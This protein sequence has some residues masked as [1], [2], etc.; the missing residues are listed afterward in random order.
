MLMTAGL[1]ACKKPSED[2]APSSG[3]NELSGELTG[4]RT[5]TS[6][7]KWLLKG[8]VYVPSGSVLTIEPGT[9]ITGGAQAA[10]IIEPGGK[11]MA[12]GTASNPIVFTSKADAGVRARGNWAGLVIAG[13]AQV[14]NA[15][16]TSLPICEGGIRTH[17]GS[18]TNTQDNESSGILKYVRVEYAGYA[19]IPGSE[20]NGITYSG[21]GRGTT[22]EYVQSSWANDDGMEFFGGCVN[23]KHTIIISAIDDD[24]DTDNGYSGKVQFGLAIKQEAQADQSG[25]K[26]FES[27]N[28]GQA[29]LNLP[30]TSCQFSNM[31]L[32]GPVVS[33][34]DSR[35]S[36]NAPTKNIPTFIAGVHVRR[37]SSL[38]LHNSILMGWNY[39]VLIDSKTGTSGVTCANI[40]NGTL[41]MQNNI[42]AGISKNIPGGTG[43][44]D[45]R[46]YDVVSVKNGAGDLTVT[47]DVTFADSTT[48]SW[49]TGFTGPNQWFYQVSNNNRYNAD[50]ADLLNMDLKAAWTTMMFDFT[51]KAGSTALTGASF[52]NV[53]DTDNFFDKTP[54]YVGA[55]KAGDT[56]TN[57]WANFDPQN[58][59]Y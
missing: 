4:N 14:N 40:I 20:L 28:D 54:S 43:T 33:M 37:N 22:V 7:K 12:E 47:T 5:L 39:G 13:N 48:L 8:F 55:F 30:L 2:P 26:N 57:G 32:I 35:N 6:D 11:I 21:V 10:L 34:K 29:S 18:F 17:Y 9:V 44:A 15:T 1:L 50:F 36:N 24:Y 27:D 41:K 45:N 31:T 49:P 53:V 58:T 46:K 56:W 3:N 38:S 59:N 25:S 16:A 52:T 42:V 23:L 51:P 19:P